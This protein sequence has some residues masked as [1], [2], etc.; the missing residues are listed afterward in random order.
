MALDQTL[1]PLTG[2]KVLLWL[3]MFFGIVISVNLMMVVF[4]IDTL[5]GTEVDSAYKASLAYNA[6]IRASREQ[7]KRGWRVEARVGR[8][9]D[10]RTSI[11]IEARDANNVPLSKVDFHARLERPIDERAD[12]SILLIEKGRGFYSGDIEQVASGQWDLVLT[13]EQDHKQLFHSKNRLV[14]D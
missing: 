2:G 1:R 3:L 14:L 13:A 12:R 8:A 6:E 5:P 10:G 9:A 7:E 4:A 11:L